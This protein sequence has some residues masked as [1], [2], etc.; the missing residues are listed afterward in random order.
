MTMLM[1][2]NNRKSEKI[3][4]RIDMLRTIVYQQKNLNVES[5]EMTTLNRFK[6]TQTF[7]LLVDE[8]SKFCWSKLAIIQMIH[9]RKLESGLG[10]FDD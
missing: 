1:I 4:A 5:V 8:K 7:L 3:F 9:H 2:V 10:Q 6:T